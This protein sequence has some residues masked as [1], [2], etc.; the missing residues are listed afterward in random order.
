[1][2]IVPAHYNSHIYASEKSI[3]V[4]LVISARVITDIFVRFKCTFQLTIYIFG[5]SWDVIYS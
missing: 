3:V 2:S 4:R 5:L 1:M